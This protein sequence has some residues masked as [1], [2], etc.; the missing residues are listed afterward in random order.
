MRTPVEVVRVLEEIW[1]ARRT[2]RA[3]RFREP[4]L[5]ITKGTDRSRRLMCL[6]GGGGAQAEV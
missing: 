1:R 4:V 3:E 6:G 5:A 2:R